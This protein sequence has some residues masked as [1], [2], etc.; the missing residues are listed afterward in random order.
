M[1]SRTFKISLTNLQQFYKLE[2]DFITNLE[3][4]VLRVFWENISKH[5]EDIEHRSVIVIKEV[6]NLILDDIIARIINVFNLQEC[7]LRILE[8]V[9]RDD[10]GVTEDNYPS[11]QRLIVESADRV[12]LYLHTHKELPAS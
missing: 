9:H 11:I 7:K 12:T 3:R 4:G 5:I 1:R 6:A 10:L 8:L 2:L